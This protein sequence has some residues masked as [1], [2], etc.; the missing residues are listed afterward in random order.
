[1]RV[2]V[3]DR[4]LSF[5]H[6]LSPHTESHRNI[7]HHNTPPTTRSTPGAGGGG[8]GG[9]GGAEG[10]AETHMERAR[11]E[12][13]ALQAD[14]QAAAGERRWYEETAV[15][16]RVVGRTSMCAADLDGKRRGA[17]LGD[18]QCRAVG[19]GGD[20]C[21]SCSSVCA[22][23]LAKQLIGTSKRPFPLHDTGQ[24]LR[25]RALNLHRS[26]PIRYL[27]H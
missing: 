27:R 25:V 11:R 5:H 24:K 14:C 9:G 12:P 2:R 3:V 4:V 20:C 1:M 16:R 10:E 15:L 17:G 18:D 21:P 22:L 23:V 6:P 26:S 13:E 7:P 8:G 19:L